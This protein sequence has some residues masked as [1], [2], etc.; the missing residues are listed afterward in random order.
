MAIVKP[1]AYD[2]VAMIE[3]E[4]KARAA[5]EALADELKRRGATF[6]KTVVQADT[7]YNAPHRDFA[8]TDEAVRLR[9]QNGAAYLTY[10]GK[11]LDAKSKTRKEVEVSVGDRA[12][13]EDILLS[14]GFR[15]TLDV[16]KTR[17][18]YHYKGAE[19]CLD[20]IDS[21]G[22]F[23]EL[24]LMADNTADIARKRDDL[25]SMLCDLGIE[26]ELIRE[27]YLEM[28]LAKK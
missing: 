20:R 27:S 7:Y 2:L 21:L 8:E 17:S 28:L 10:K 19:I 6:E 18:I 4:I 1:P 26:G 9:E 24:E 15:K 3:V 25:I 14:L 23:V 12:K 11:K 16:V 22:E 5:T 13:M